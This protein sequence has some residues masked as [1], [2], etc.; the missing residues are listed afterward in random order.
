MTATATDPA[1]EAYDALADYYDLL[2][3]HHRH[4]VWLGGLE[5]LARDCGLAG[6]RVLDVGCGTGKS[7]LPLARRGYEVAGCD[8]SARMLAHAR[9]AV[10]ASVELFQADMRELPAE[11]GE[12]D[13]VT[14]LDDAV[15]YVLGDDDLA[16]ALASMGRLL[17]PGGLLV[18]DLNT[19]RSYR[20]LYAETHVLDADDAFLCWRGHGAAEEGFP[21]RASATIEI[22][23]RS[24][25][26]CWQRTR[27]EHR[28]R[29]WDRADVL[30][31]CGEAGL[32]SVAT[33]GQRMGAVL[34][35]GVD[36]DVHTKVVHVL[37]RD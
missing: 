5:R 2:T 33:R 13:L 3:A 12:F 32:R 4:D 8:Q 31:A 37:R 19:L 10:P 18:F 29:H 25:G 7:L 22:F 27:S 21:R 9:A 34:E 16:R 11:A 17:A 30:C 28:Q 15:N 26:A 23:S 6:D 36:E 14:C 1:A 35:H 24:G 20:T